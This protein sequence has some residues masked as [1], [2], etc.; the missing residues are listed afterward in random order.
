MIPNSKE[1][2]SAKVQCKGINQIGIVVKD[3]ESVARNYWDILGI[4]PWAIIEWEAP[5]VYDRRYH[6]KPVM[7]REKL[8]F[9]QAGGVQIELVQFVEGPS[10]Y[11]DWLE[12]R[13]EGLH[14]LN[15]L[16]DDIDETADLLT[17]QGF[18]SL[19]SGRC[20]LEEQ[21]GGYNY[22][23]IKPLCAIL[24]PVH[25]VKVKVKPVMIP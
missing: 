9:A 23:D 15:F 22:I 11:R 19:Q 14:H 2:S 16:V 21:K 1:R 5:V 8:A 20:G 10:I 18:P 17:K 6:G 4:G 7:A 12:E 25:Q 24:E 13:G 3:A